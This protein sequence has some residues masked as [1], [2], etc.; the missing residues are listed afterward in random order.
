ME[1]P[2]IFYL[3]CQALPFTAEICGQMTLNSQIR[4]IESEIAAHVLL[5]RPHTRSRVLSQ[6][7]RWHTWALKSEHVNFNRRRRNKEH[8]RGK[9]E[10]LNTPGEELGFS[11]HSSLFLRSLTLFQP[12]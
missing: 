4:F 2:H 10:Q 12:D 11:L 7:L 8:W 3:V 9:A 6:I 1:V 5:I